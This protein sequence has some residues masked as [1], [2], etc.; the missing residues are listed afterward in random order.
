[1]NRIHNFNAGPAT[2]PIEVLETVQTDLLN[3][4]KTG[5]SIMEVSHRSKSFIGMMEQ[6]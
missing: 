1:M 4:K 5:M 6:A 3:W 2:L